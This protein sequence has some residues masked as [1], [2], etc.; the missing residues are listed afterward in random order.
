MKIVTIPVLNY[1]EHLRYFLRKK[2]QNNCYGNY[3]SQ[4]NFLQ[5]NGWSAFSLFR[6]FMNMRIGINHEADLW[7]G[8]WF[9][10][11]YLQRIHELIIFV[12]KKAR[13]RPNQ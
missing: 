13:P 6:F 5:L 3:V 1:E 11:K 2:K 12:F 9:L 8:I 7:S 10:S 4:V